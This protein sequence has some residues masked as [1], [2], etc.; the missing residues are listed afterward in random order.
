[1]GLVQMMANAENGNASEDYTFS[2]ETDASVV[3]GQILA[4]DVDIA[5]VPANVAAVL[6]QKTQGG[7]TVLNINT[8]GVLYFVSGD[9][10]IVNVS[11]LRG[12][13]IAL[14]GKGTTPDYALQ[15]LLSAAGV[16]LDEVQL[17]YKAEATEVASLLASDSSVVGFLPQPFVTAALKQNEA[18]S[19]RISAQEA[20]QE[21]FGME[22]VTGVTIVRNAFLQEN[23]AAVRTFLQ[24][25]KASAEKALADVETTAELVAQYGIVEKAPVAAAAL[26]YCNITYMDGTAMKTALAAYLEMLFEMDAASVGGAL[27][28]NDFYYN[29]L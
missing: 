15:K 25:E 27:P 22:L 10:S 4:G 12:K 21:A 7:V 20:W 14:T 3:L 18:L 13:T 5:L 23:E 26:P 1:M 29:G 6:Y 11:D 16:S 8:L 28:E 19:I 17:E 24:E 9:E 2:M